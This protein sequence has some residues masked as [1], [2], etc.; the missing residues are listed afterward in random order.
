MRRLLSTLIPFLL[1]TSTLAQSPSTQPDRLQWFHQARFGMFIHWGL[2]AIPAGEWNGISGKRHYNEWIQQ[3]ARIPTPDY[4]SF[5]KQFNPAHFDPDAI[6]KMA[7]AAGMKYIVFTTKHH[8]GFCM[9]DSQ[10]T[11]YTVTKR[12]P[13]AQDPTKLLADA[14]HREGLTFCVYYSL[15]D[16]HNP[17]FPAQYSMDN[18]H[19][20]PS[21][22][23]DI[24]KYDDYLRGQITELLTHYGPIGLIW[25][26]DGGMFKNADK[27]ALLQAPKLLETIH[28]LQPNTLLNDR[29]GQGADYVTP[30]QRIPANGLGKPFEVCMTLTKTNWGYVAKDHSWKSPAEVLQKLVDIASKGG[31]FLL[32]VGPMPSGEIPQPAKDILAQV[33]Q[34]TSANAEALYGTTP[35]PFPDTP[36]WGR[37][38]TGNNK[39]YLTLFDLPKDSHY[40]LKN[41][42]PAHFTACLLQSPHTPLPLKEQADT[43]QIDLTPLTPAPLP[44]VILLKCNP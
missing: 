39:W 12:T 44:T 20:H 23:A 18:F 25:F 17:N 9:F 33:G 6:V 40:S 7:K 38:T 8:D 41:P 29:L 37:I 19:A 32:N 15:P 2:Y 27:P 30:E 43:L 21:P 14:C 36:T 13:W 42:T 16:W 24:T 28:S 5:A 31:N 22:S 34:W 10:L 3:A 1:A 26:D 35:S 4:E 11:D